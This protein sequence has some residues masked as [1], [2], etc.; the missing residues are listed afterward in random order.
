MFY[1]YERIYLF[2][3]VFCVVRSVNK[4]DFMFVLKETHKKWRPA[5]E[6]QAVKDKF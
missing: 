4:F 5:E 2:S 1:V 3:A 6:S